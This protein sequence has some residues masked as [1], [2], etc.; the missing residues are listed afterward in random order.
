MEAAEKVRAKE[1]R[2]RGR[3]LQRAP[4]KK[5]YKSKVAATQDSTKVKTK[6]KQVPSQPQ[7]PVPDLRAFLLPSPTRRSPCLRK[8]MVWYVLKNH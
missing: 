1:E 4:K 2:A 3:A 8:S 7:K 5:G 6:S